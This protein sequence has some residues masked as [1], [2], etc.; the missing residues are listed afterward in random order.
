MLEKGEY[1]AKCPVTTCDMP[2]EAGEVDGKMII[3]CIHHGEM[4][5]DKER[6]IVGYFIRLD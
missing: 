5:L 3:Q 4:T 6:G 1:V 2:I